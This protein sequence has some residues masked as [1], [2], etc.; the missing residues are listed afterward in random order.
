MCASIFFEI[1]NFSYG[2]T[3]AS[4]RYTDFFRVETLINY[5]TTPIIKCVLGFSS[6]FLMPTTVLHQFPKGYTVF[7]LVETVINYRTTPIFK[8][9]L[10]FSL[11]ILIPITELHQF[12]KGYTIFFYLKPKLT[13][14]LH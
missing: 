9:V 3:S 11:I 6:K 10:D 1:L 12:P 2:S 8:C 5:R 13:T 4:E 7:F 14:K